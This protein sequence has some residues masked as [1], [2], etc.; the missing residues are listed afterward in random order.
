MAQERGALTYSSG[1]VTENEPRETSVLFYVVA[2]QQLCA[3][4]DINSYGFYF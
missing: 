2:L 4:G 1:T 3:N